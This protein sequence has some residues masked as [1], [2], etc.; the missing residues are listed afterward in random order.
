MRTTEHKGKILG[1]KSL[2]NFLQIYNPFLGTNFKHSAGFIAQLC[3][4]L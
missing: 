3:A 2:L 4:S 1:K